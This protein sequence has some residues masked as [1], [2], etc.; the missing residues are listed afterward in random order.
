MSVNVQSTLVVNTSRPLQ[1]TLET[2]VRAVPKGRQVKSHLFHIAPVHFT[3]G[4]TKAYK[5]HSVVASM[6]ADTSS[7]SEYLHRL[8]WP[9]NTKE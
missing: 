9:T 5:V 7:I 6:T 8:T 3:M 2:D 4:R 1:Y